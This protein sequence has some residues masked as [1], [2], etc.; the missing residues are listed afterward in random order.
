MC[1]RSIQSAFVSSLFVWVAIPAAEPQERLA[2][3]KALQEV[4]AEARVPALRPAKDAE[5]LP[6]A[7]A[8]VT[9][10]LKE[11]AAGGADSDLRKAVRKGRAAIWAVATEAGGGPADSLVEVQQLRQAAGLGLSILKDG[12]RA[13]ANENQFKAMLEM[14][15]RDV[16]RAMSVLTEVHEEL[17]EAGAKRRRES[18]RW[19]A[20]YDFVKARLEMQIAL[21]YEYQSALGQMRKELPPRDAATEGGWIL[22]SREALTGD[23]TG[24]KLNKSAQQTLD[25]IIKEHAGTPWEVLA[26]REKERLI[27]LEWKAGP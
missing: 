19:Q 16:A 15:Q 24:K 8:F 9:E 17:Q 26:R 14:R 20:N 1:R 13:P 25:Y 21:L 4:W 12:V 3:K 6:S 7:P 5:T 2:D 11:Y 18:K 23:T 27:G 10:R 22:Q